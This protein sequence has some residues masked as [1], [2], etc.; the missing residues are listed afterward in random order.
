VRAERADRRAPASSTAQARAGQ[1]D[2]TQR[3]AA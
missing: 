1:H 3:S 2:S